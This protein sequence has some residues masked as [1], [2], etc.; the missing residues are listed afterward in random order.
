MEQV[1]Y[2]LCPLIPSTISWAFHSH[3]E[4]EE[5]DSEVNVPKVTLLGKRQSWD[6]NPC[7]SDPMATDFQD[8]CM[9]LIH[10]FRVSL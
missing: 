3:S 9:F 1:F 5:T 7:F 2:L 8:L 10:S 4:D 6:Y